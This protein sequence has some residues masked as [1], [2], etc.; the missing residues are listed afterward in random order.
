VRE[1]NFAAKEVS[2]MTRLVEHLGYVWRYLARRDPLPFERQ[3]DGNDDVAD[4]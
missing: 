1:T 3:S 2:E 4:R